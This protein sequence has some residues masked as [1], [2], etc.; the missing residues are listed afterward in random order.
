[1]WGIVGGLVVVAVIAVVLWNGLSQ[2]TLFF[3]NVDQAVAD[4][5]ELGDK[6]FRIQ[7]N[8]LG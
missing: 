7:G 2:A 3:Y 1:M 5:T 6:R 8:E 4:R